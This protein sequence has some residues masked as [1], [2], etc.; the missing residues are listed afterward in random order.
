[1]LEIL[2]SWE[3]EVIRARYFFRG[4]QE[5][6]PIDVVCLFAIKWNEENTLR[7]KHHEN[8]SKVSKM[9]SKLIG[10]FSRIIWAKLLASHQ[11]T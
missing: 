11:N 7:A 3:F 8:R 9:R 10:D 6:V 2:I 4:K 1:M 5:L